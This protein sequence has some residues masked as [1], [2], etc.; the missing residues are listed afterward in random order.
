MSHNTVDKEAKGSAL[1][2][3]IIIAIIYACTQVGCTRR[4]GWGVGLNLYPINAVQVQHEL[5]PKPKSTTPN[6]NY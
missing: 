3:A 2:G 5:T 6:N 4:T 1:V